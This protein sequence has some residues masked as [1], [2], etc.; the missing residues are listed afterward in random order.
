MQVAAFQRVAGSARTRGCPIPADVEPLT[1]SARATTS[2]L[3]LVPRSGP[4]LEANQGREN[5]NE[6]GFA[7]G[8]PAGDHA[9]GSWGA[10]A[11]RDGKRRSG[12]ADQVGQV[13]V[14]TR[15]NDA[16]DRR[17]ASVELVHQ[18]RRIG[19]PE[20]VVAVL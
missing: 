1:S 11:G 13:Q 4:C 15:E 5:R 20:H 12:D 2:K 7:R 17:Q 19:V 14:L 3:Y 8:L 10:S 18:Q 16:L 9:V 6:R